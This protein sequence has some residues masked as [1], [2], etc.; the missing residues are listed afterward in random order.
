[1]SHDPSDTD[2][3]K[4]EDIVGNATVTMLASRPSIKA[5][6][7]IIVSVVTHPRGIISSLIS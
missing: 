2:A 7:K 5:A 3:P 1:M 6:R 4:L